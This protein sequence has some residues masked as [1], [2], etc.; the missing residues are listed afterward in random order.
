MQ[1]RVGGRK[2]KNFSTKLFNSPRRFGI[3]GS[4]QASSSSEMIRASALM[5][6][7][8]VF[9]GIHSALTMTIVF[10]I[11]V[12]DHGQ[13]LLLLGTVH[14]LSTSSVDCHVSHFCHRAGVT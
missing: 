8:F 12:S 14:A 10:Y 5:F 2:K 3:H 13:W 11:Q 9:I 6:A 7:S 1:N 4:D